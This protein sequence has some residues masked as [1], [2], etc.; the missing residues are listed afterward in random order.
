MNTGISSLI[1]DFRKQ[2][3][4]GKYKPINKQQLILTI[5]DVIKQLMHQ[6][7]DLTI[8]P[9]KASRSWDRCLRP[10]RLDVCTSITDIRELSPLKAG[11]SDGKLN[12]HLKFSRPGA[13]AQCHPE[14]A[15]VTRWSENSCPAPWRPYL[16][17]LLIGLSIPELSKMNISCWSMCWPCLILN[18][19]V[20]L[21][22]LR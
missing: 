13:M 15:M 7:Y 8:M 11:F 14:S 22:L 1:Y 3:Q 16:L 20:D 6:F 12:R 18:V 4:T 17:P 21:N 19:Q 2:N 5:N 9:V 10:A